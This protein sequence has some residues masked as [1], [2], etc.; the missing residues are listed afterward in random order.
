MKCY[1][2]VNLHLR[3]ER[4]VRTQT[5]T[6]SLKNS[7]KWK[8]NVTSTMINCLEFGQRFR[9]L[10]VQMKKLITSKIWSRK[11]LSQIMNRI[12]I[13]ETPAEIRVLFQSLLFSCL[14]AILVLLVIKYW[15]NLSNTMKLPSQH[16]ILSVLA[17][18]L[19][20]SRMSNSNL[21]RVVVKW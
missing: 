11:G 3:S 14:M 9:L 17:L 20:P 21:L 12:L 8:L 5:Q 13:W 6:K 2:L 1:K 10:A 19:L 16:I 7:K 18:L 15:D 4:L